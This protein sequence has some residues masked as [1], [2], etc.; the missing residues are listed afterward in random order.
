MLQAVT[1]LRPDL[2]SANIPY[3][4]HNEL[5]DRICL[6]NSKGGLDGAGPYSACS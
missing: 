5:L 6:Q 1:G 4:M 3:S 2:Q